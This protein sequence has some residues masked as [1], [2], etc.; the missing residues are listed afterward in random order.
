MGVIPATEGADMQVPA[1]GHL[2]AG[3][4]EQHG[5]AL[6]V[7]SLRQRKHGRGSLGCDVRNDGCWGNG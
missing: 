6:F 4:I 3:I 1:L 7:D 5:S 2:A